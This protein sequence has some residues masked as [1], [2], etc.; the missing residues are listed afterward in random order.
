MLS[1]HWLCKKS[2]AFFPVF[3]PL[4]IFKD[5]CLSIGTM[6]RHVGISQRSELK[7]CGSQTIIKVCFTETAACTGSCFLQLTLPL[8]G[9][10]LSLPWSLTALVTHSAIKQNDNKGSKCLS[11]P[12]LLIAAYVSLSIR[13]YMSV[14]PPYGCIC[15]SDLLMA[16][17]VSLTSLWLYM[18]V[19][20]PYGCICQSDI[21]A[22]YVGLASLLLYMSV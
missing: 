12:V 3:V 6:C 5:H 8:S 20:P 21:M 15:Q 7:S 22:V 13:L 18:S 14:W 4:L 10:T 1:K 2:G 19:W 11:I 9:A 16:V 17:Y